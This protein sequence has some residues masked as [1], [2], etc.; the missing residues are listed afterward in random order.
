MRC[1]GSQHGSCNISSVLYICLDAQTTHG[2]AAVGY[3]ALS[4][5]QNTC[6]ANL[7]GAGLLSIVE[8]TDGI[9]STLQVKY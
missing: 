4:T 9:T 8:E 3:S 5:S 2:S 6:D 1:C 7:A